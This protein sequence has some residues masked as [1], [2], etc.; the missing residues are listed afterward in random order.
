MGITHSSTPNSLNLLPFVQT[1]TISIGE[2]E[3]IHTVIA[4]SV[5]RNLS[6]FN[7]QPGPPDR[8]RSW[9]F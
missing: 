7:L 2:M 6:N 8:I 5:G 9:T 4:T 1:Q 3:V